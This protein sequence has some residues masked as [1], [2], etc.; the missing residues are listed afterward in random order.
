MKMAGLFRYITQPLTMVRGFFRPHGRIKLRVI[1][2]AKTSVLS[3]S[4]ISQN[5]YIINQNK[6]RHRRVFNTCKKQ[7]LFVG[8]K[9]CNRIHCGGAPRADRGGNLHLDVAVHIARNKCSGRQFTWNQTPHFITF[10][11]FV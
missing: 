4:I 11:T 8:I 10:N 7:T 9:V 1:S 5:H 6:T 3:F 2:P